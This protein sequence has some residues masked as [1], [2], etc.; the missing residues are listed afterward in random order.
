MAAVIDKKSGP[1]TP[2]QDLQI[3][4]YDELLRNG[5]S[6]G[7]AFDPETHTFLVNGES[8]PSVTTI[9]KQAGLTPDY[10]FVDPWYLERGTFIHRATELWEKGTLD[11]DTVDP[12]ITGYLTAYKS[13]RADWRDRVTGQEVRLWHP[14]YRYAGI[15]DMTIDGFQSYKLYLRKNGKYK[16][17]PVN[18]IKTHFNFFLSGLI[19]V[20][21]H[22]G[23]GKEIAEANI[24]QW[25]KRHMKG[26]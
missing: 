13:F 24:R 7:L 19:S 8:L 14:R 15:I 22:A 1:S 3:S 20:T 4:A 21:G 26:E 9:I 2:D 17:V 11:D 25:R 10:S 18:N 23:A 6:E 5:T 12:E 16:L